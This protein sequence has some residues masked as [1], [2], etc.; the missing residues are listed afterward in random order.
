MRRPPQENPDELSENSVACFKGEAMVADDVKV[1]VFH[2][3]VYDSG[4]DSFITPARKSPR[5][6]VAEIGGRI[7]PSTGEMV[8]LSSLDSEGRYRPITLDVA[9]NS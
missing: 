2:F 4:S 8:C 5:T 9:G 7:V 6:R 1:E 3:E